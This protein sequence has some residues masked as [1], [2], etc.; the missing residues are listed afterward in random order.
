MKEAN[1][2]YYMW[3]M[4][5]RIRLR[6]VLGELRKMRPLASDLVVP[7]IDQLNA[8]L[9]ELDKIKEEQLS[10]PID[11]RYFIQADSLSDDPLVDKLQA[12]WTDLFEVIR[13]DMRTSDLGKLR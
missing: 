10:L 3:I 12:G 7:H 9:I 1:T 4:E 2:E 5:D 6:T 11:E 13:G 8:F